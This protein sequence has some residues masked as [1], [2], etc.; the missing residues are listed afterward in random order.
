[1]VVVLM[2]M[3]FLRFYIDTQADILQTAMNIGF[4]GFVH[5]VLKAL[6]HE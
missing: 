5:K 2:L 4:I 6:L 3:I 1:M